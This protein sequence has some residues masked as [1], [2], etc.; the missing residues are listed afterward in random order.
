MDDASADGRQEQDQKNRGRKNEH[1]P[2]FRSGDLEDGPPECS[3]GSQDKR[4]EIQIEFHEGTEPE[5]PRERQQ[6]ENEREKV[7]SGSRPEMESHAPAVVKDQQGEKT[8]LHPFLQERRTSVPIRVPFFF[9][10]IGFRFSHRA[11]FLINYPENG[12]AQMSQPATVNVNSS[13]RYNPR[14]KRGTHA[15]TS[16]M[17]GRRRNGLGEIKPH[18]IMTKGMS[19]S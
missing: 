17:D 4:R 9:W 7:W 2:R 19:A 11:S 6:C 3:E 13:D 5:R 16:Q 1:P 12:V 8:S 10:N 15:N 18:A 14:T